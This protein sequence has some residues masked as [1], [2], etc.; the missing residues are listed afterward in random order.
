MY[1]LDTRVQTQLLINE[2]DSN[3]ANEIADDIISRNEYVTVAYSLKA[4]TYYS[5]GD[6]SN[7][8]KYKK[9][10]FEKAPFAYEEYKEYCYMLITGI[11]LYNEAGDTSSA[12]IC[13]NQLKSAADS[14]H[15]LKNKLSPLGA[16]IKDQPETELPDD[17]E[18]YLKSAI[19][20]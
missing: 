2:T 3:K 16:K 14:V 12:K 4:K 9:M 1:P 18:D 13:L 6:F 11:S 20:R 10:I 7:V 5:E 17:I 8:I 15:T 19:S